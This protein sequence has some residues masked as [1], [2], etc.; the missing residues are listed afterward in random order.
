MEDN[1]LNIGDSMNCIH[2]KA[3]HDTAGLIAAA[4]QNRDTFSNIEYCNYGKD[5]V[6]CGAGPTLKMYKPIANAMHVALNRALLF[7]KVKFDWFIAD[8]WLGIDFIAND[9]IK[10][11]CVKFLGRFSDDINMK[12]TISK[13][14]GYK[15]GAKWFYTD[16]FITHNGYD[17]RFVYDID[18]RAVGAMPNI[19]L[20]ALQI[21]LFSHPQNVYLV[22]CDAS[23]GH[24]KNY[25]IDELRNNNMPDTVSD[26]QVF[27][28]WKNFKVF[29]ERY[30][31]D[32]KIISINPVGL[33][34]M[35][36]DIYQDDGNIKYK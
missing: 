6:L 18:K 32:V 8:D 23:K 21:I 17:G 35:F 34:G 1:M 28:M 4:I 9:I 14:F 16:L 25:S 31:P 15:C 24:F 10:Y 26:P 20:E 11:D 22:G 27:Q 5:V 3:A 7:D 36:E 19:A 29:A 12:E 13:S 2:Y 30:Y 33:K